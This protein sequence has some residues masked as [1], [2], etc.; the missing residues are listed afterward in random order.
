L[1]VVVA[2]DIAMSILSFTNRGPTARRGPPNPIAV[3]ILATILLLCCSPSYAAPPKRIDLSNKT[4]PTGEYELGFCARPSPNST[5]GWPGHAFVSFSHS[6]AG[7]RDFIAIG[8]TLRAGT[9]PAEAGWS[10]FGNPVGGRLKEENY[11][12]ALADCLV[13]KVNKD[14]YDRAYALTQSPLSKLGLVRGNTIVFQAYKLGA[15]DCVDFT[16]S[17]AKTLEA[18]GLKVPPRNN[19]ERPMDYLK[20]LVAAN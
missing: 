9:S 7:G 20:R 10:L 1:G 19:L 13:V 15:E 17:L 16:V 18:R 12:S 3:S 8:H 4:D 11:T 14:D 2:V 6:T 5:K